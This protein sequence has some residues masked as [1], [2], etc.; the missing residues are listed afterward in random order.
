MKNISLIIFILV[1][2][3]PVLAGMS[4]TTR[5]EGYITNVD[6]ERITLL[7][8]T[9]EVVVKRKEIPSYFDIKTNKKVTAILS[10]K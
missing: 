7:V 2:S 9:K 5:I 1:L 6:V 10:S 4:K 3:Q 8:G